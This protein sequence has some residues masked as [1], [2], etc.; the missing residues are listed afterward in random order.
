M[1]KL[2]YTSYNPFF[3]IPFIAWLV[4]GGILV[5]VVDKQSLFQ[6]F[7]VHHSSVSDVIVHNMTHMGEFGFISVL[8]LLLFSFS[9]FR[10]WWY[11]IT[12]VICNGL[13]PLVI[14][15]IKRWFHAPRPLTYFNNAGWIHIEN[16]WERLYHDSFPSGHSAGAFSLFCFLSMLLPKPYRPWALLLFVLGLCVCYSRMYLAAHFFEDIYAGSVIGTLTTLAGFSVMRHY[17]PAPAKEIN[18]LTISDS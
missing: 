15:F 16:N 5:A 9:A 11:F 6:P 10:N 13:P 7:N 12:A 14:Q 18:S 3:F 4:I 17:R 2:P 8:L 1:R